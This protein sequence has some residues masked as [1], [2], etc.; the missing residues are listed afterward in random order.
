[1]VDE[2]GVSAAT[3]V[4]LARRRGLALELGCLIPAVD[5]VNARCLGRV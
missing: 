3:P 2:S 1:M 4:E 5:Y